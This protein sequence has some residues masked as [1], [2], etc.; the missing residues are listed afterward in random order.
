MLLIRDFRDFPL[1]GIQLFIAVTNN[2]ATVAHN[3]IFDSLTY[4]QLCNGYACRARTGKDGRTVLELF[5]NDSERIYYCCGNNYRC[6]VLIVMEN[7]NICFLLEFAFYFKASR[8]S[9][10]LKIYSAEA[11]GEERNTVYNLVNIL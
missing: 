2:A 4:E 8:S 3:Y 6:A 1:C 10:V 7:R 9:N 5:F 11:A